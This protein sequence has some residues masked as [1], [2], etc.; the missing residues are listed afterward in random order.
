MAIGLDLQSR[1][2]QLQT[3]R[4][5]ISGELLCISILPVTWGELGKRGSNT[6]FRTTRIRRLASGLTNSIVWVESARLIGEFVVR[7]G[8][9]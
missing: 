7:V 5:D 3:A 1:R 6:F 4:T 2:V 9:L 8:L